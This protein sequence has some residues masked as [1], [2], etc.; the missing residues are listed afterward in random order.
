M[1]DGVAGGVTRDD[2]HAPVA[3][4]HGGRAAGPAQ[5]DVSML[6]GLR[7]R[8]LNPAARALRVLRAPVDAAARL[9]GAHLRRRRVAD[10]LERTEVGRAV[11][12][13]EVCSDE[14]GRMRAGRE[15]PR[16][17]GERPPAAVPG[18]AVDRLAVDD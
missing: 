17:P 12:A 18:V 15:V 9:R 2:G 10:D 3:R 6:A 4:G 13:G 11:V 16:R 14:T 1:L 8:E 5:A 7:Q